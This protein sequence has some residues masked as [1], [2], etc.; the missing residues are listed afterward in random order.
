VKTP[1]PNGLLG[2]KTKKLVLISTNIQADDKEILIF[3]TAIWQ[4]VVHAQRIAL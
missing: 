4:F 1:L 2:I 3:G